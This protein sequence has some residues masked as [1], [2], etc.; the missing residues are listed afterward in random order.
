M[1]RVLI[2]V[3]AAFSGMLGC[4]VVISAIAGLDIWFVS[5]PPIEIAFVIVAGLIGG[6]IGRRYTKTPLRE[7]R[8]ERQIS[9]LL[10]AVL[11]A[12]ISGGVLGAVYFVVFIT[13]Y[14]L[15]I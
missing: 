14:F 3:L 5:P 2:T 4:S 15:T 8:T 1:S 7:K 9:R 13:L 6:G 12:L 11:L 10:T